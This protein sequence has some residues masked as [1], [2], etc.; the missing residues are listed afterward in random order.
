MVPA[1]VHAGLHSQQ[2]HL[3]FGWVNADNRLP[4][5]LFV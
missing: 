2:G 4:A 1:C 5:C 3:Y